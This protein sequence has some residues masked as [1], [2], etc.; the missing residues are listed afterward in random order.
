[1]PIANTATATIKAPAAKTPK[2]IFASRL[3]FWLAPALRICAGFAPCA[4]WGLGNGL[5][6][7]RPPCACVFSRQ[8]RVRTIW[9]RTNGK[10]I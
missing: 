9:Y 2:D 10:R 4:D 1:M 5:W 7:M 8:T 3:R 6:L